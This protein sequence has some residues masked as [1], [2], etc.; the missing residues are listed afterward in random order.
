MADET[1]GVP[2]A[3]F[4]RDLA[5]A[6]KSMLA[7]PAGH[8]SRRE[9]FAR[10]H[11]QL[12]GVLAAVSPLVLGVS[13]DGL[14]HGPAKITSTGSQRLA[15]ALHRQRV[16]L[17][18]IDESVQASE[19]ETFLA[20]L[21]TDR[22]L[23]PTRAPQELEASLRL[24]E[25]GVPTPEIIAYA[26]YPA[27]PLLARSDVATI[28]VP[29]SFDLAAVLTG[30]DERLRID[31]LDATAALLRALAAAGAHHPDLNIKNV[32]LARAPEG[33]LRAYV[34]DVDR[35]AFGQPG[36][37][38]TGVAN[39]GRLVR[40]ARKWRELYGARIGEEEL[41]RV[42]REAGVAWTAKG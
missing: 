11:R 31:A 32:L 38:R 22:F 24:C 14:I 27:G 3:D 21:T 2:L 28:L 26:L 8:P 19:L 6:W 29:D 41:E 34:L 36:R 30:Q 23:A 40:S 13:R 25:A 33:G 7:Y 15:E 37:A 1:S 39:F 18:A 20:S 9:S 17:V 35:V 16:A 4:L 12:G 10:A 5:I 42:A